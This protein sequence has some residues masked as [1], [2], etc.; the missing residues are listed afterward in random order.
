MIRSPGS[1]FDGSWR[2]RADTT[3]TIRS[4]ASDKNAATDVRTTKLGMTCILT[5]PRNLD[6]K[7]GASIAL[8]SGRRSLMKKLATLA[9]TFCLLA[10]SAFAAL[11]KE[12]VKR[13]DESASIIS[14]MRSSESGIPED[15]WT[16]AQ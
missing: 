9:C 12:E 16:K 1:G 10:G 3:P 7:N 4:A 2:S 13:L 11:T 15:A 14:E 6:R 5:C 8:R